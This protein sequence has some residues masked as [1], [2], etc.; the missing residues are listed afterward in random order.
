MLHRR[1]KRVIDKESRNKTLNEAGAVGST[2][3]RCVIRKNI[4]AFLFSVHNT[5][6]LS[7]YEQVCLIGLRFKRYFSHHRPDDGRSI[8]RNVAQLELC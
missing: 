8:Y 6:S 1:K 3:K 7:R 4:F 2:W 5:T